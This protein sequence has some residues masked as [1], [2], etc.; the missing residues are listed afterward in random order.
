MYIFEETTFKIVKKNN[1]L[2]IELESKELDDFEKELF[3]KSFS[4]GTL[5]INGKIHNIIKGTNIE[6]L[7]NNKYM[8]YCH[9]CNKEINVYDGTKTLY[10]YG[11]TGY[12]CVCGK[13]Y[14][15]PSTITKAAIEHS[16]NIDAKCSFYKKDECSEHCNISDIHLWEL[17][18]EP[19]GH[20]WSCDRES[21]LFYYNDDTG[22]NEYNERY[23]NS[24]N[25]NK[26]YFSFATTDYN[27][28]YELLCL[29]K[30]KELYPN[31]EIIN[32]KNITIPDEDKE[33]LKGNYK[34]FI[35]KMEKYFFPVIKICD[36]LIVAKNKNGKLY[37]GVQKEI[38]YAEKNG[39][40]IEYL[41]IQYPN[42]NRET[43]NCHYCGKQIIKAED[44]YIKDND[45]IYRDCCYHCN[46]IDP[47]FD[48][49]IKECTNN[50]GN[51]Q[52]QNIEKNK[53]QAR[54]FYE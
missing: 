35:L 9:G 22:Q 21:E 39:I 42:P 2:V 6:K 3:M 25:K 32:P 46:G 14:I 10:K 13:I 50:N 37:G 33:K 30:I 54:L 44:T 24:D 40:N 43:V 8:I 31:H 20:I 47:C 16:K 34:N 23:N 11:E 5:N 38:D 1:E 12:K 53:C 19:D 41:N 29:E 7:T 4:D 17:V 26:G 28:E 27:T 51:I 48:C 52:P 49:E 18:N 36:L 15:D 45:N